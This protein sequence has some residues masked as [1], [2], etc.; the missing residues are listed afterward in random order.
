VGLPIVFLFEEMAGSLF[1]R[2][3]GTTDMEVMIGSHSQKLLRRG[4][5]F[6]LRPEL[7]LLNRLAFAATRFRY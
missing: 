4:F 5:L 3:A 7:G 6:W 2:A 1:L